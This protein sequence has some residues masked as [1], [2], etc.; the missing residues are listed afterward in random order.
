MQPL[1][2]ARESRDYDENVAADGDAFGSRVSIVSPPLLA[3]NSL[4]DL[5]GLMQELIEVCRSPLA[6][7]EPEVGQ[8]TLALSTVTSALS[9]AASHP[10]RRDPPGGVED[11]IQTAREAVERARC[12]AERA[13]STR[14]RV[15]QLAARSLPRR[16]GTTDTEPPPLIRAWN[17]EREARVACP[18]C[19]R[20]V[21]VRYRY[22]FMEGLDPRRVDCPWPACGGALTFYFPRQSFDVSVR[23]S[24]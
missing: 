24:A 20:G 16:P 17:S 15:A 2:P 18:G 11:A 23:L 12:A 21:V 7:S 8:A 5:D 22:R 14:E 10:A 3:S 4:V 13:R 1:A 19:R 6:I 9:R